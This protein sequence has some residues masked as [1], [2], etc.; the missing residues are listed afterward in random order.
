MSANNNDRLNDYEDAEAWIPYSSYQELEAEN[1]ELKETL[2]AHNLDPREVISRGLHESRMAECHGYCEELDRQNEKLKTEYAE[3]LESRRAART[4]AYN[5]RGEL[6]AAQ[7]ALGD[8]VDELS[9]YAVGARDK[10]FV[11]WEST[12]KQVNPKNDF[13]YEFYPN[14]VTK[15]YIEEKRKAM[16]RID[17][18]LNR[19]R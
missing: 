15:E 3:L 13:D 6:V 19:E 4:E 11:G 10:S 16:V 18:F 12:W 9:A 1:E 14:H 8:V 2:K 17:N 5:L 7:E